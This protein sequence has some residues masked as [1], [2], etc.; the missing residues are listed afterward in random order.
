MSKL[1]NWEGQELKDLEEYLP[2]IPIGE[3]D[4]FKLRG[5]S[6]MDHIVFHDRISINPLDLSDCKIVFTYSNN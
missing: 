3:L 1:F 6:S 5:W 4:V 2:L